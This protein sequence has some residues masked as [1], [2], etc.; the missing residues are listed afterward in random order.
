MPEFDKKKAYAV[1]EETFFDDGREEALLSTIQ[2][3]PDLDALKGSPQR[4]LAAIDDYGRTQKY[5]MNVGEDKG[6]IVAELIAERA[7]QI[8]VPPLYTPYMIQ[9]RD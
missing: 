7:P 6:R 3:R 8:M 5:L 4:V 1:Q 2:S 9:T